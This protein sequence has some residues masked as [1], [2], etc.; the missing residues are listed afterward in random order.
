MFDYGPG[1]EILL[2]LQLATA[3]VAAVAW[4][5]VWQ[6]Q[7]AARLKWAAAASACCFSV[8]AAIIAFLFDTS[9]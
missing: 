3:V 5:R 4:T 6:S 7:E 8:L 2:V 9:V 1:L